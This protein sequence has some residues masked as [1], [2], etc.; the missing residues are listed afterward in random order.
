VQRGRRI[1]VETIGLVLV[2]CG[3]AAAGCSDPSPAA[4][5]SG[6]STHDAA[7][8]RHCPARSGYPGDDLCIEP[9]RPSDGFQIH[10]G[11]ARYDAKSMKPFVLAPGASLTDCFFMKSPN[12]AD[13]WVAETHWRF[14]P[15]PNTTVIVFVGGQER[16]DGLG[17]CPGGTAQGR[18][19]GGSRAPKFDI[20]LPGPVPAE[21]AGAA[22]KIPGRT[23]IAL[24]FH[25][26]NDANSPHLREA[27]VN[28]IWRD[29]RKVTETEG[30]LELLAGLNNS[31]PPH[32]TQLWRGIAPAPRDVALTLLLGHFHEHTTRFTAWKVVGASTDPGVAPA[33][34]ASDAG[35]GDGGAASV[36]PPLPPG[37]G[38]GVR[39][40]L[41]EAYDWADPGYRYL[42][43]IHP[44]PVP[45]PATKQGGG[46]SGR[47]ELKAGDQLAWECEVV[48]NTDAPLG[49]SDDLHTGE[50]CNLFGLFTPSDDGS[51]WTAFNF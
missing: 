14:R 40:R 35:A 26:E 46:V 49:F 7:T 2:G 34:P 29:A 19:W 28:L 8:P 38:T 39:T 23:Q 13:G 22:E 5:D 50:M 4:T 51:P 12:A 18:M 47:V 1:S 41:I 3:L 32:G 17:P 33:G 24:S 27:W 44:N 43:S 37:W 25:V 21:I 36:D 6:G 31:V 10:Y 16:A 30:A 15:S 20:P 48:N 11:P 9:P 42:D 45:D